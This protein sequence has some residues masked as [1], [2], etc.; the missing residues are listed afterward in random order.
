M[1]AWASGR[2]HAALIAGHHFYKAQPCDLNGLK[3]NPLTAWCLEQ[4]KK[5]SL[6]TQGTLPHQPVSGPVLPMLEGKGSALRRSPSRAGKWGQ[7]SLTELQV[8]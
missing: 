3:V 8:L 5:S 2:L 6:I 7:V 4:E 1:Q